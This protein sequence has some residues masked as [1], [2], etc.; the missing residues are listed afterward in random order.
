MRGFIGC[1]NH[2][3]SDCSTRHRRRPRAEALGCEATTPVTPPTWRTHRVGRRSPAIQ[4]VAHPRTWCTQPTPAVAPPAPPP[5]ILPLPVVPRPTFVYI[6]ELKQMRVNMDFHMKT[7][8]ISAPPGQLTSKAEALLNA[9]GFRVVTPSDSPTPTS[10]TLERCIP[11]CSLSQSDKSTHPPS[12][13]GA[14]KVALRDFNL[15][16]PALPMEIQDPG[17]VRTLALV[18]R[19][20]RT[21]PERLHLQQHALLARRAAA[22]IRHRR[23]RTDPTQR[24]SGCTSRWAGGVASGGRVRLRRTRPRRPHGRRRSQQLGLSFAQK[25][26]WLTSCRHTFII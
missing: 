3:G 8:F 2:S 1:V 4:A 21:L 17:A 24:Q 9:L 14:G 16:K 26:A 10:R 19:G 5:R 7:C 6:V 13:A 23:R 25:C 15:H 12:A 20:P 11:E 22:V 18:Q